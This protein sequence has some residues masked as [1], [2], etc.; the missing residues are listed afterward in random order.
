MNYDSPDN[1][2]SFSISLGLLPTAILTIAIVASAL[3]LSARKPIEVTVQPAPVVFQPVEVRVENKTTVRPRI[4]VKKV[5]V[6]ANEPKTT[7]TADHVFLHRTPIVPNS[8]KTT[9][10]FEGFASGRAVADNAR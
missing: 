7:P 2:I 10:F 3:M 8:L 6:F 4:T 9:A 5:V 1:S